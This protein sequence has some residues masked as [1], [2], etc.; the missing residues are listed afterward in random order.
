MVSE[1]RNLERESVPSV[2]E[3]REALVARD[4]LLAVMGHELRNSMAPLV[5]LASMF[6]EMPV[7][8]TM[9][10]RVAMLSRNLRSFRDTLDRII[11]VT[12]LRE[13][14]LVLQRTRVDLDEVVREVCAGAKGEVRIES[15]QTPGLW[16]RARVAQIVSHL[17]TNAFQ[18]G[19]PPVTISVRG[20]GGD[21]ELV[22][23]DAGPGIPLDMRDRLF[24]RFERSG[25]RRAKGL[26][27]GLWVV[28]QLA[29]AMGGNV[30]LLDSDRGAR[31]GVVL[32]RE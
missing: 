24:Q 9:K 11:E 1:R 18:H 6:E 29:R 23:Q 30:R 25:P 3:L 2:D 28:D 27:V 8:D 19:A 4:E 20:R 21:V 12:S 15:A 26:G 16:D 17:V 32:P 31:F 5:L 14:K 22:V 7:D 13:G 10:S